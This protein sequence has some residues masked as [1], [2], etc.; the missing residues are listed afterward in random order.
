MEKP[1]LLF[2]WEV[3]SPFWRGPPR[4]KEVFFFFNILFFFLHLSL[5]ICLQV[6]LTDLCC[7]FLAVIFP[8]YLFLSS[9]VTCFF[10]ILFF[11]SCFVNGWHYSQIVEWETLVTEDEYCFRFCL[12]WYFPSN[13][14]I[15]HHHRIVNSNICMA[16]EKWIIIFALA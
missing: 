2:V 11:H 6:W 4:L 5:R 15:S 10:L 1:A 8:S 14:G 7:K 9:F 12:P 3:M 13:V 16:W